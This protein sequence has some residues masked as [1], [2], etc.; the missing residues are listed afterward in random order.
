MSGAVYWRKVQATHALVL[1]STTLSPIITSLSLSKVSLLAKGE[2]GH[3]YTYYL[4]R[5]FAFFT[6]MI[7]LCLVAPSFIVSSHPADSSRQCSEKYASKLP[8]NC[9]VY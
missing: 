7:V 2:S 8:L 6:V 3:L 4:F 9:N 1:E 5:V